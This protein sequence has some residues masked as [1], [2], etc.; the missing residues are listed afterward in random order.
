MNFFVKYWKA[1]LQLII[2]HL[3]TA[4]GIFWGL[5]FTDIFDYSTK[6]AWWSVLVK[7]FSILTIPTAFLIFCGM[8]LPPLPVE[9][10]KITDNNT[11]IVVRWTTRGTYP[12][13][14]RSVIA[15]S[16]DALKR[17][18]NFRLEVVTETSV[19]VESHYSYI[20]DQI[21]QEMVIPKSYKCPHGSQFK[22]RGLDYGAKKSLCDSNAY[23][24]H[25]DEESVVNDTLY[26]GVRQFI[27]EH[28]GYIGQGVITYA[29]TGSGIQSYI[30][31]LA[32]SMRTGDDFARF[33]FQFVIGKNLVGMKGSFM[34][35]PN[36]IEQDV[37]FD[38]GIHSS[39]T[40]DAWFAMCNWDKIRFCRGVLEEQSPFTIRDVIKQRRRWASG[41]WKLIFFHPIVWW[42]KFF[43]AAQM[44]SW[45]L[46][47][48]II[49]SFV[50]AFIF[51]EYRVPVP[52]ALILGFNFAM[53]N[54]QYVW[55]CFHQIHTNIFTKLIHVCF[56]PFLLPIFMVIEG[57]GGIYGTFLPVA[58]FPLVQKEGETMMA[59]TAKNKQASLDDSR[60]SNQEKGIVGIEE[61]KEIYLDDDYDEIPLDTIT[62]NMARGQNNIVIK[63]EN[64]Y[65]NSKDDPLSPEYIP[66]NKYLR[67]FNFNM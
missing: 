49:A 51:Y 29:N 4:G 47:P 62:D 42:K 15:R 26:L 65:K 11:Q 37:G 1:V 10:D 18:P 43:L 57:I 32:D 31:H 28:P 23:I 8:I 7:S 55:G 45:V 16:Y 5:L 53:F 61:N 34:V 67:N 64:P 33:R 27:S 13:L 58:G 19:C 44:L 6:T 41:L 30:C 56:I 52:I 14:V 40:E 3:F 48:L 25:L 54:L 50:C 2:L 63:Y 59:E 46:S 35:I 24:L 17:Y 39:I 38:H 60:E 36:S 20:T 22:A 21:Y 9:P 12:T 66:R